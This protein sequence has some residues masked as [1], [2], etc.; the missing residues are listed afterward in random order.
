MNKKK[1]KYYKDLKVPASVFFEILDTNVL[2]LLVIKGS[3]TVNQLEKAFSKIFDKYFEKK[4]DTSLKLILKTRKN[5]IRL[6]R[7]IAIIESVVLSLV[8]FKFP[9]EHVEKLIAGLRKGGINID[10]T[11]DLDKELLRV[12]QIDLEA[13]RTMLLLEENNLKELTKGKKS[14]FEDGIVSIE[15]V[16][17][18]SLKE[19]ITLAKYLAYE[20]SV[21]NKIKQQKSK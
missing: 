9:E 8:K 21:K 3:P 1:S 18:Y 13:E 17:G 6:Y 14:S 7:K 19:D 10:E 5:I 12:L 20:A 2:S 16:L 15:G 11:I 4:N